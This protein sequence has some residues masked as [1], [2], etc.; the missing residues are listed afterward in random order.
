MTSYR[1]YDLVGWQDASGVTQGWNDLDSL[2]VG[3][4]ISGLSDEERRSATTL[5]AMANAPIY[6]GGDLT[7]LD[8]LGKQLLSNEEVIAVDRSG[9]PARQ[10][11]GGGTPVWGSALADGTYY[12]ALFNLNAFPSPVQFPW[13]TLGF[14]NAPHVRDL[15][16][17]LDLPRSSHV[18]SAVIPGHGARLLQL[19]GR[20]D[21]ERSSSAISQSY[22][23]ESA[24]LNGTAVIAQCPACSGGAKVGGLCCGA[25]N[26]MTFENIVVPR[27]GT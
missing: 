27:A 13:S 9:Q 1:F 24:T 17:H 16:N 6:L 12:V 22:E 11:L 21:V 2:E 10:I 5:W 14:A 3:D 4:A 8:N 26:Y 19:T 23:A 25:N 18:F 15:W 7:N 20:G